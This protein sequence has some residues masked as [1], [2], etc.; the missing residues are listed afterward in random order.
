VNRP[1]SAEHARIRKA[2]QAAG[3]MEPD[4]PGRRRGTPQQVQ[5]Y[6]QAVYDLHRN[7][8]YESRLRTA[9][10]RRAITGE[11]PQYIRL[12]DRV[13]DAEVPLSRFQRWRHF[14]RASTAQERDLAILQRTSDRQNRQIRRARRS[15]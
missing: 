15:R 7:A 10:G 14:G 4:R 8:E 13:C 11:T 12:N 2:W 9:D 3:L 6:R 1:Q 5:E